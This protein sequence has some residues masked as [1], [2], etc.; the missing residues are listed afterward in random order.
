MSA[1]GSHAGLKNPVAGP[2]W[3]VDD[4]LR[5]E[6]TLT[7]TAGASGNPLVAEASTH[8]VT[9]GGKRVRPALTL[10]AS[11]A[12]QA[13]RRETDLAAAAVEL[14]HLAS[15]YHDDVLDE[16]ETRRGVLTA[17][18]K[19]GTEIAILAG[20]YLFARGCA[21]GA[22]ASGEVP[23]ILANA[24]SHVCEGQ[25]AEFGALNDPRRAV[26]AYI[27]TISLK[28]A[29]LFRCACEMG[30]TTAGA[31]AEARAA[32]VDFGVNLGLAFQVVDDL[33]DLVGDEAVTGKTPGT[34]LK[35]GVFTLPVLIACER[36]PSL[37]ARLESG[38]RELDEVLP[39][40]RSTR[41]LDAALE[42]AADYGRRAHRSLESLPDGDWRRVLAMVV[43]GILAQLD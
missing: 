3:L 17:H 15:L 19:W 8:L 26:D 33:L 27:D 14:V 9:A 2:S 42:R 6:S 4:L 36:D 7:A 13:G 35:E 32:L 29:A 28:T 23:L 16:T 25:I 11:R 20:D 38:S 31:S 5:V 22:Q 1:A 21:L 10:L 43:H 18:S 40:L 37:A 34:D 24:I 39:I 30:A 12:G 41:A